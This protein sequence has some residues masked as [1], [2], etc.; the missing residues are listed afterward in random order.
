VIFHFFYHIFFSLLYFVGIFVLYFFFEIQHIAVTQ[1]LKRLGTLIAFKNL[2]RKTLIVSNTRGPFVDNEF[3]ANVWSKLLLLVK[4]KNPETGT[5]E[6]SIKA[7]V[8]FCYANIVQ[9][10][11]ILNF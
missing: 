3:E 5:I 4:I 10:C 7:N 1:T 2:T 9:A 11:R 6:V 8:A